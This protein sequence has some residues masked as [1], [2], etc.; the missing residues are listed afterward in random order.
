MNPIP[1][2]LLAFAAAAMPTMAQD[3]TPKALSAPGDQDELRTVPADR[4]AAWTEFQQRRPGAWN[5]YWN[6][7]TGTPNAV[8]GPGLD[9][10]DWRGNTI[11]EAR[12]QAI[13][14]LQAEATLL[15]LGNSDLRESIGARMGRLWSF[16][17]DQYYQGLPVVGGRADVRVGMTGRIAMFG[18]AAFAIP[19]D[20]VTTPAI[21]AETANVAALQALTEPLAANADGHQPAAPRLVIWG[22]VHAS[23]RSAVRLAWEVAVR[24]LGAG[25]QGTL[26]RFYVDATNGTVLQFVDDM[27]HCMPGC[28]HASHGGGSSE[29]SAAAPLPLPVPTFVEVRGWV[30]TGLAPTSASQ[31]V[32]MQ[33]LEIDVPGIGV[34]TTDQNGRITI[35]IAAPVAISIGALDG[36]H[37]QPITG[38]TLPSVSTTV[39]PGNNTVLTIWAAGASQPQVAHTD[40]AYWIERVNQWARGIVGN[41]SQMTTAS[42]IDVN[43][44]IALNCNAYYD[45]GLNSINFYS[46]GGGCPNTAYSTVILH[47]WGHGLDDRFGGISQT[48]GLSEGWG[49]IVSMYHVD[50][51]DVGLGILTPG[52]VLR[53]GTNTRQYPTGSGIHDQGESW[54]GFAWKLRER[55]AGGLLSRA[56]AIAVSNDIVMGSIVADAT[57][58]P[59]AVLEVFLADDDD[60]NLNNGTPHGNDITWACVQHSLPVPTSNG[61]A[62][63]YCGG[64]VTVVAGVNGPY[65]STNATGYGSTWTCSSPANG[66]RDLWFRY[67]TQWPGLL[68]AS[69]CG[70]TTLDTRIKIL[71]GTCG[72]LTELACNNDACGTQSTA[73]ANV[74]PGTTY[75]IVVDSGSAGAFSLDIDFIGPMAASTA[76]QGSGCGA[77]SKAFYELFPSGPFDLNGQSLRLRN[78]G[79]YYR[80]EP[81]GSM[82]P[83]TGNTFQ[84]PHGDD[85]VLNFVL[86]VPMP[87]P[88][89]SVQFLEVCSNGFVSV[90]P[91]NGAPAFPNPAQ[92]LNSARTCWGTWHDFDPSAAGSG[93]I[94][95]DF[96]GPIAYVTWN[97]VYTYGT[98][99]PRTWQIQF[100]QY[101]GDVTMVW[102]SMPASTQATLVG[103]TA[104]G[105][106]VDLGNLDLSAAIPATFFTG[107]FNGAPLAL[108]GTL[109]QIGTTLV[110]T[111]T[112]V[113]STSPV[114]LQ[115]LGILG[116]LG[117]IDLSVLGMP[118]CRQY[119]E[120]LV[121][122]TLL[123]A[124]G[125]AVHT[126]PIPGSLNLTGL[127]LKA[128]S[129]A[130]V[131]G[132]NAANI[133]TSNGVWMTVGI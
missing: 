133:I 30:R 86:S 95:Y 35:D 60:F 47:E 59:N 121:I 124:A 13:A 129:A 56:Q 76:V 57:T 34:R 17:F 40:S 112:N 14:L 123:P 74:G 94:H 98:A 118:G 99:Q 120:A 101:T 125:Q 80:A 49:D 91:G 29:T 67:T 117:G 114:A 38:G 18:S 100:D 89:G 110:L 65:D 61:P 63:D 103:Y 23:R 71:S 46:A 27:H 28:A 21:T 108:S 116:Y 106:N 33:G 81:G 7:A 128:Q 36:R 11:E 126:L 130:L 132:Y 22:D 107:A 43:V 90:G 93:R 4:A 78:M 62:N 111:T 122:H 68:V 52:V 12:R 69:T 6:H 72:A 83:L 92:W 42:N 15:G 39:Q 87:Y 75:Y 26:G 25:G 88:G 66:A 77:S 24:N 48:G 82:L 96:V 51:P 115:T 104:Q 32:P 9:L 127:Q 50:N 10:P 58:Q 41:G 119:S 2:S 54:M 45:S 79:T 102:Q 55:L 5:A 73:S 85:T 3:L 19:A 1:L 70:L 97:N 44:N 131:A 31:L 8:Y 37:H 64:A 105:P 16:K 84:T 53:T 20:F 109:P 113:P